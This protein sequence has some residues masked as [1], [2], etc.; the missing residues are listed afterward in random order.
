CAACRRLLQIIWRHDAMLTAF[1]QLPAEHRF[2]FALGLLLP[3]DSSEPPPRVRGRPPVLA[4][5]TERIR[6]AQAR[7]AT[8]NSL[9]RTGRT[10]LNPVLTPLLKRIRRLRAKGGNSDLRWQINR[11]SM[12]ANRLSKEADRFGRFHRTEILP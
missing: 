5:F 9:A 6:V 12:E 3:D 11:H 8:A 1:A 7:R 4:S 10:T 2:L